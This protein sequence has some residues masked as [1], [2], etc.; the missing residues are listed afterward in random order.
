[1][2]QNFT[3]LRRRFISEEEILRI[4]LKNN[5]IKNIQKFIDEVLLVTY[6]RGWLLKHV[7][8][9]IVTIKEIKMEFLIPQKLV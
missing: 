4:V 5:E 1:M 9:F 3:F 2:C 6:W 7:H 8:G